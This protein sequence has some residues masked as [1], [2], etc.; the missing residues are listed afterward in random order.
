MLKPLKGDLLQFAEHGYFDVVVHGCNCFCEMG[1]GFAYA[2]KTQ[3]PKAHR[4]DRQTLRGDRNKLGTYTSANVG[5]FIIVNAYTQYHFEGEGQRFDYDALRDVMK[6]I[7]QD[8]SGKRIGYP[9]I[10][11]GFAGGCWREASKIINRELRG[12]KH[13]VV[14]FQRHR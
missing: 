11:A 3:Y 8:F 10:G 6:R 1:A 2:V 12:E 14:V 9:Q 7:K 13:G 4:A 5:H